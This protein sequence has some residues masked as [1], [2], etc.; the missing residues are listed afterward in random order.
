[1]L[2]PKTFP[3]KLLPAETT[4]LNSCSLDGRNDQ[5]IIMIGS[6]RNDHNYWFTTPLSC[7]QIYTISRWT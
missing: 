3:T 1:L 7:V 2:Q 5:L 4:G 6:C